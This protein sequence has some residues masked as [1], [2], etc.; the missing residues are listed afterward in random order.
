MTVSVEIPAAP[1][2]PGTGAP[3]ARRVLAVLEC[4]PADDAVLERA[5]EVADRSGGYLTL[6]LV[7]PPLGPWSYLGPYCVPRVTGEELRRDGS[8]ALA[9][10]ASLVPPDIP[11][12]TALDHGRLADVIERRVTAASHDLVVVARQ[13]MHPRRLRRVAAVP[14]LAVDSWQSRRGPQ[15]SSST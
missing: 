1:G 9:R 7:V 6:V 5:I 14:V 4:C 12:I 13:R 3:T 11:L 2:E 15:C 8:N 10:A